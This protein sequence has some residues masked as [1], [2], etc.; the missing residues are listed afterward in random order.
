MSYPYGARSCDLMKLTWPS[1][2][3]KKFVSDSRGNVSGHLSDY[4][5][6]PETRCLLIEAGLWD[7]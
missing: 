7:E 6:D 3:S 4:F 2:S 1:L 5:Y